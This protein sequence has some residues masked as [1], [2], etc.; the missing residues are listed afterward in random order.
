MHSKRK[1]IKFIDL[2]AGVGGFHYGITKSTQ[3]R[4]RTNPLSRRDQ[5][6]LRGGSVGRWRDEQ[7]TYDCVY[8]N[9]WDKYANSVYKKHF[10]ECDDRDITAVATSEIPDHDLLCAGFPCQA[11]SYAGK[12]KG[13]SDTRGTLFYE[14][15]RIASDKRP[16]CLLLENV[17]GL[18]S[19]RSG[20]TFQTILRVLADLGYRVEWQVLNSKHFGVPQNR[21]RIFII[22]YLG[23]FSRRKVFP[24]ERKDGESD[25]KAEMI[26]WQ[27]KRDGWVH[28]K[29][30]TVKSIT[31][32]QEYSRKTWLKEITSGESISQRVYD[33]SGVAKTIH[34][35][36]GGVGAKTGLY[37]VPHPIR[38]LNRNQK[39]FDKRAMTVDTSNSTG[40]KQGT[41]IRRLTPKECERLQGFPDDWTKYGVDGE[42]MSDT[43]R[44]KMMGNAVTTSVITAIID[45]IAYN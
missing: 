26:Y 14:V 20:E 33:S 25:E 44:Y 8:A 41:R 38:F 1:K 5:S 42:E 27:N 31:G 15:A 43:Q 11:F 2:F 19:H 37:A 24:I 39:N 35:T 4:G 32:Q 9:E 6:V 40:I 16:R 17:K 36:G 13:F 7:P 45:K 29:R 34:G 12:K 21:E 10:G 28:K 30:A 3:G 23:E 22:G 18:L